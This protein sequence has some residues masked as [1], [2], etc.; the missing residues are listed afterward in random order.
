MRKLHNGRV[1]SRRLPGLDG[2]RA[3]SITLVLVGHLLISAGEKW[4]QGAFG[5]DIFFVLSGYLI[6]WVLLGDE[7]RSGK[8]GLK[9]FYVRRALRILP[10]ALTYL[11]AIVFMSLCGWVAVS[12]R[13]LGAALFFV[14]NMVNL[15]GPTGHY[16]TLSV[17]EQF[18]L[19]W[20]VLL[21]CASPRIRLKLATSLL[22][23]AVVWRLVAFHWVR[24][25]AIL[26]NTRFD[27]RCA[28]LLIGC[29]LALARNDEGVS[30]FLRNKVMQSYWILVPLIAAIIPCVQTERGYLF[31]YLGIA[32]II[33]DSV[34]HPRRWAGALNWPPIEWVGRLS[35]SIYI[36][37]QIFCFKSPLGWLGHFPQNLIATL[38]M[39][40]LS[41]YLIEQPFA[42]IRKRLP[43]G[44]LKSEMLRQGW[45]NQR[46]DLS[47]IQ[48]V[49]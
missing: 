49:L 6:T 24:S 26:R 12:W 39:S 36:W 34:D 4:R 38:V 14:R 7:R 40:C 33:N 25:E 17:E 29:V 30:R 45:P 16:W 21:A 28:P 46:H 11:G 10:P 44:P 13:E 43:A 19:L 22:A 15:P 20:P 41:Y 48:D 31:A 42:R 9:D 1:E 37:Q 27:V 32:V 35:Y 18:Y 3:I 47:Q 5:V 23:S 8:I 2:I